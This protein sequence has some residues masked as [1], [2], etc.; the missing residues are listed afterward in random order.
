VLAAVSASGVAGPRWAFEGFLP[1]SGRERR[2]RL[3]RIAADERGS[4]LFEAPGR[5]G[6]TLRDLA[7]ACGADRRAA[8]CRE[9][10]KIHES[11][12][13]GSLSELSS[14]AADGSIPARG[15][16]VIVVGWGRGAMPAAVASDPLTAAREEVERLVADGVGRSEAAKRVAAARGLTRR[17]LYGT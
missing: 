13:R 4:V 17:Q 12:E 6:S 11:I 7:A 8:V 10:T 9:L 5:V 2:A 16:I 1:R 14:A 15:E 3:E